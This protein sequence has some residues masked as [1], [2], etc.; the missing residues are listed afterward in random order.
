MPG[1]STGTTLVYPAGTNGTGPRLDLTDI[2]DVKKWWIYYDYEA[3][4]YCCDYPSCKNNGGC[5][6][7]YGR[8]HQRY[9]ENYSCEEHLPYFLREYSMK[10]KGCIVPKHMS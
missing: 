1:Q 6:I 10:F 4:T 5:Y 2:E 9:G 3:K 8:N 7:H